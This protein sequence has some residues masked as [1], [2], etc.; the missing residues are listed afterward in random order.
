MPAPKNYDQRP[1]ILYIEYSLSP[2]PG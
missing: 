1:D 2:L